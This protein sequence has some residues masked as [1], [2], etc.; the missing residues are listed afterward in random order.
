MAR[1]IPTL[2]ATLAIALSGGTAAAQAAAQPAPAPAAAPAPASPT[3]TVKLEAGFP[4]PM[5]MT[6]LEGAT[7]RDA[8]KFGLANCTGW[9]TMSP[10]VS[11]DLP[12]P[13]KGLKVSSA[14]ASVMVVIIGQAGLCKVAAA[15]ESPA[16]VMDEWPAGKSDIFLGSPAMQ[17]AKFTLQ[18]EDVNRPMEISW[19]KDTSIPRVKIDALPAKPL[20]RSIAL[21]DSPRNATV[22]CEGLFRDKPEMILDLSAPIAGLRL[23][24]RSPTNLRFL[25]EGPIA[26]DAR[27]LPVRCSKAFNNEASLGKLEAGSYAIYGGV[28]KGAGPTFINYVVSGPNTILEPASAAPTIPDKLPLADRSLLIHFPMLK[29]EDMT[30]SDDV[31]ALMFQTA[32][33]QLFVFAGRDFDK[34]SATLVEWNKEDAGPLWPTTPVPPVDFPKKNEPLLL[35]GTGAVL[36]VDGLVFKV[37]VKDLV[38]EKPAALAFPKAA[39]DPQVSEGHAFSSKATEDDS[40]VSSFRKLADKWDTCRIVAS[41]PIK[42]ELE[43]LKAQP[44]S[45]AREKKIKAAEAKIDPAVARMCNTAA[46]EKAKKDGWA[47]L[48]KSRTSRRDQSRAANQKR[49]DQLFPK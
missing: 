44:E 26:K 43:D 3:K 22:G 32:P 45:D 30:A 20:V 39:R 23:A 9:V 31:R 37:D 24:A 2:V 38:A 7:T 18:I 14:G 27:N 12:K 5:V 10:L 16:M 35:L 41:A 33:A 13:I 48:A 8:A 6:G 29:L 17:N 36:T 28:E 42:K 11:L 19:A 46:M 21:V 25:V 1:Y 49:A 40:T 4:N 47:K 15:N 34:D